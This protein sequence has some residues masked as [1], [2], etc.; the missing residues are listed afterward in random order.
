MEAIQTSLAGADRVFEVL[1]TDT[2]IKDRSKAHG[3]P[4]ITGEITFEN[5]SFHYN[6]GEMILEGINFGYAR[7][8]LLPWW[9]PPEWA[10]PLLPA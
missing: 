8:R 7:V 4:K 10:R 5:V 1:E 9:G 3:L 6:P 2:D